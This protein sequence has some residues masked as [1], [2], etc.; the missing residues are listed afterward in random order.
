M[1]KGIKTVLIVSLLLNIGL[2]AGFV[3]YKGYVRSA[4][5]KLVAM[6]AQAEESLLRDILSKLETDDP[7]EISALKERLR[8]DIEQAQKSQTIWEQAAEK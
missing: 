8:R 5:F 6:N 3:T 7:E 1:S 4:T 2:I